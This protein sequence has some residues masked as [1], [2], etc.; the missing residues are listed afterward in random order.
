MIAW[1]I[2]LILGLRMWRRFYEPFG[3]LVIFINENLQNKN[4]EFMISIFFYANDNHS[5]LH[6]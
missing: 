1:I 3:L 2:S 5:S 4:A 6:C